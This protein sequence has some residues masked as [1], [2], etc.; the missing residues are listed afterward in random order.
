L[1]VDSDVYAGNTVKQMLIGKQFNGAVR[2]F[3]LVF[4]SLKIIHIA[5]FIHRGRTFDHFEETH[6]VFL[7]L[8]V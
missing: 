2:R 4:Y 1:L 5:T 3:T 8:S 6:G 7:E